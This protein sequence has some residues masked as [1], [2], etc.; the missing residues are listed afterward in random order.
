[1]KT[2]VIAPH[3]D[4]E[5]LG[6]GGTLLSRKKNGFEVGWLLA[7]NLTKDSRTSSINPSVRTRQIEEVRDAELFDKF[8]ELNFQ[9]A[10]LSSVLMS[11]LVSNI[12]VILGEFKP[13]EILIP[14]YSDIHSDHRIIFEAAVSASK[15]FRCPSVKRILAYETLSETNFGKI[16]NFTFNANYFVDITD[17][18]NKKLE[19]LS[20]YSSEIGN[21]PFPRSL[22]SIKALATLRG[23]QCGYQYAEAFDCLFNLE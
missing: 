16:H 18:M 21:H 14:H 9:P 20:I 5:I 17:Q 15:I 13:V 2:L 23:S 19:I 7:T 12:S 10:S 8:Y 6:T 11:E 3:A 1:M 4:D 22:D